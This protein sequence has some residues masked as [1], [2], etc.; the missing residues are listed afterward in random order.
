MKHNL[1]PNLAAARAFRLLS[2]ASTAS[3][4]LCGMLL[5]AAVPADPIIELRFPEGTNGVGGNGVITTN[6][7]TFSGNMTFYQIDTNLNSWETNAFPAFT[8]SI[9]SWPLLT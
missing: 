1:T 6:T 3:L 7:G 2:L 5:H 4:L 9:T 8:N